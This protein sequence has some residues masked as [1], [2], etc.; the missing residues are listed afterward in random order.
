MFI[1]I[2]IVI[3]PA[4]YIYSVIV[5]EFVYRPNS[6]KYQKE[7]F[8]QCILYIHILKGSIFS[9]AVYLP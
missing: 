1:Y 8:S 3:P 7:A 2:Y 4:I 9:L 6:T 5:L